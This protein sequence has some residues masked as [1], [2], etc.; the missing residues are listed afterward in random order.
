MTIRLFALKGEL[1][2]K[3]L[4]LSFFFVGTYKKAVGTFQNNRNWL[5]RGNCAVSYTISAIWPSREME[6]I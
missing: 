3:I 2:G 6:E 1:N 4:L 5:L